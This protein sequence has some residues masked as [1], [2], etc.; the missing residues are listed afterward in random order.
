MIKIFD[1]IAVIKITSESEQLFKNIIQLVSENNF[2]LIDVFTPHS[3]DINENIIKPKK[4]YAGKVAFLCGLA[5]LICAVI[6]I[7]YFQLGYNLNFGIKPPLPLLSLIPPFFVFF[8]LFAGIGVF[9]YF[10]IT[11]NILPGQQP[12]IY[13][14]NATSNQYCLLIEK[15]NP[16]DFYENIFKDIAGI[17]IEEDIYINQKINLPVPLKLKK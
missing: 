15:N 11:E 16:A 9:V 12:K 4:F 10:L 8:V 5:G 7:P 13:C 3:F 14:G 17:K 1:K 6:L 2:K